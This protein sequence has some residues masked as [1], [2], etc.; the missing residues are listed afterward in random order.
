MLTSFLVQAEIEK[1]IDEL[2][3]SLRNSSFVK[4]TLGNYKGVEE[5]LQ[6][7]SIRRIDTR[8]GL[9]LAFQSRYSTRDVV[10]NF[11]LDDG[12]ERVRKH[13]EN[14]F[15]SGHLFTIE[16]DFQ[17]TVG[18]KRAR[19]VKGKAS[20]ESAPSAS[21]D[22]EK[23]HLVDP[24][25]YYLQALGI[26]TDSGHVRSVQRDKWK[27]INKFV[28]VLAGLIEN[29]SLKNK[30]DL[31]IVDMGSGK[32]YL[33]FALYDHL[34]KPGRKGGRNTQ[35]ENALAD[36]QAS[37]FDLRV[38][39]VE[40]RP[41]LIALCNDIAQASGFDGLDFVEG[42][43]AN[44]DPGDVDILIALHACDTATDDAIYKGL[45]ACAEIIVAAPCCHHE[46]K[47]QLKPPEL[48]APILKHPVMHERISETITDGIRSMLLESFGYKTK[49]FEFVATEHT[50]KNNLLVATRKRE[51]QNNGNEVQKLLDSFGIRHQKLYDLL[52]NEE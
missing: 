10:K 44:F 50:P 39:G 25:A 30:S 4:L 24:F 33:T 47:K 31:R 11:D 17:L 13:L 3:K 37:P 2:R 38:T 51:A 15:R 35:V 6:K 48:L 42:T 23:R 43:I 32:G 27:Q 14:G 1:F 40:Q 49:M 12:V 16:N 36:A 34:Q 18:K 28:E 21:H 20:I 41:D 7:V 9:R 29:S 46:I 45:K 5:H 26:T 19:L 8:K 22:R 52:R